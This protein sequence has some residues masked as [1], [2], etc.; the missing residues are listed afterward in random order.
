MEKVELN[1]FA[2][3][4]LYL[5]ENIQNNYLLKALYKWEESISYFSEEQIREIDFLN[6]VSNIIESKSKSEDNIFFLLKTLLS[7][8]YHFEKYFYKS[9]IFSKEPL[10]DKNREKI[11]VFP[12]KKIVNRLSG[13]YE[14]L[15]A[16]LNNLFAII[17]KENLSY[18]VVNYYIDNKTNDINIAMLPMRIED[19]NKKEKFLFSINDA[20][21]NNYNILISNELE[22]NI[23]LDNNIADIAYENDSI[24]FIACPT[25]NLDKSNKT[26]IYCHENH[27]I[28]ETQY[29]KHSSY[30]E[31]GKLVE[32]NENNNIKF[33]IFHVENVGTIGI[34]ICKDVFSE[35]TEHFI[36]SVQLDILLVMSYT[37][38]YNKFIDKMNWLASKKRV[39]L[40]CNSCSVVK[41]NLE[42]LKSPAL[43]SYYVKKETNVEYKLLE[44]LCEF[45]CKEFKKCYFGLNI[46]NEN[47]MLK[48]NSIK[49][50]LG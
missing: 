49:H 6:N 27:A 20:I 25:Y 36:E 23:E 16:Y 35:Y 34:V 12:K 15:S 18:N 38:V 24:F 21:V 30:T 31:R 7:I 8:D 13:S 46:K 50:I 3:V 42:K 17:I 44:T 40:L 9:I 29:V 37:S 26:T 47:G 19:D 41:K 11:V 45:E 2:S 4:Y 5:S 28:I 1:L 32:E 14:K 22:G 48:I 33:L 43:I 10:N 39:C